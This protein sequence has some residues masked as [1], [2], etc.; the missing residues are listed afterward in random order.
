MI[1]PKPVMS[2]GRDETPAERAAWLAV[3]APRAVVGIFIVAREPR[4]ARAAR[5]SKPTGT[6]LLEVL[7]GSQPASF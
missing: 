7:L 3:G 4:H 2:S 5:R 1:R 6:R